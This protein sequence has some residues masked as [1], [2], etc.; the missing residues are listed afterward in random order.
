VVVHVLD[1]YT[2]EEVMNQLHDLVSLSPAVREY[3]DLHLI[4]DTF[5]RQLNMWRNTA[6]LFAST[7]YV[8]MLDIDLLPCTNL[9]QSV[10][11]D[12]KAWSL[13]QSGTAAL[14]V[15]AFEPVPLD[16][17]L[18][19]IPTT[20]VSL[21]NQVHEGKFQMF[22]KSRYDQGHQPTN[23]TRWYQEN[24]VYKVLWDKIGYE[25]YVIF[26]TEGSPWCD[27]RFVG[28][29]GDKVACNWELYLSGKDFWV[30]PN[31]FIIHQ[32]HSVT[33]KTEVACLSGY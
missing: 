28:Y 4:V 29:G 3:A 25:P 9:R 21:V 31:D 12:E 32:N 30:L 10:R 20:K 11:S 26:K 17:K 23:Y 16:H 13:L 22:Y 18:E 7:N 19:F 15:P 8:M 27:E 24:Q 33:K 2:K 6:R 14:V 5:E 1:D